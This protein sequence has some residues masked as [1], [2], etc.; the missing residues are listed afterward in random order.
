M[1]VQP[2]L[3][4]RSGVRPEI[5]SHDRKSPIANLADPRS[6]RT[7]ELQI[8]CEC[9]GRCRG[10]SEGPCSESQPEAAELPARID[11]IR[12]QVHDVREDVSIN[13]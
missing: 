1:Q 6:L 11:E 13:R 5:Q 10:P 7:V 2:R 12:G 4:S 8:A 9:P 3:T